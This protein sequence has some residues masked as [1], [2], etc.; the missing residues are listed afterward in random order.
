MSDAA[1]LNISAPDSSSSSVQPQKELS[2]TAQAPLNGDAVPRVEEQKQLETKPVVPTETVPITESTASR[3][4]LASTPMQPEV[5][6]NEQRSQESNHSPQSE[7]VPPTPPAKS[8]P[9]PPASEAHQQVANGLHQP[10]AVPATPT[11]P[12]SA[13]PS[14]RRSLTMSKGNSVSSVL[15]TSALETISASKEARRSQPL[16][17]STQ[18]ALDMIRAGH[19]G[20]KPRALFE[21]LRLACETR[22]E[23][24]MIASLDCISKLI[25]YSFFAE[26]DSESSYSSPPP[27]PGGAPSSSQTQI[28]QPSLVDL[29]AHTITA[30]HTET[31]P[32]TVSLQIV[33]ALLALVLSPTIHV[34]HSSLLKAVRTV[35]NVFL[36]SV[37]PVNQ[38]V[39]QG[40][41]TQMVHHIFTRCKIPAGQSP[42]AASVDTTT[43]NTS[44]PPS[45]RGSVASITPLRSAS[46]TSIPSPAK[47]A[48]S[49]PHPNTPVPYPPIPQPTTPSQEEQPTR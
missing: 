49:L 36:L 8:P 39:A 46:E 20:D 42:S 21:P 2:E 7:T 6:G 33:K 10:P 34:H 17:E 27:S 22:N 18:L 48:A 11:S 25:S 26:S 14:H 37:D 40:G 12:T 44:S 13:P 9:G 45:H 23:K 29:V 24:L 41:L 3:P 15:I 30:C 38:M 35:Y 28:P 43:L 1:Q 47:S 19:G 31:T 16:R 4:V 32:E 5:N